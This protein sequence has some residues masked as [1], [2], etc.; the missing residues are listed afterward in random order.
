MI[1]INYL[2]S[3]TKTTTKENTIAWTNIG[4]CGAHFKDSIAMA[5]VNQ[6]TINSNLLIRCLFSFSVQNPKHAIA[7]PNRID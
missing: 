6:K 7:V 5:F 1:I 3:N 4:I 2:C